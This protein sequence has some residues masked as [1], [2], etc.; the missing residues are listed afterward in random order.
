MNR[1]LRIAVYTKQ[2]SIVDIWW[3]N[4]TMTFML[5]TFVTQ[6]S[7]LL[8]YFSLPFHPYPSV[9]CIGTMCVSSG[10]THAHTH[11]TKHKKQSSIYETPLLF[12]GHA[13]ACVRACVC[14][15][16]ET[17]IVQ[18]QHISGYLAD[19]HPYKRRVELFY[20]IVTTAFSSSY[21]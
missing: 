13:W 14:V 4:W 7:G 17:F 18:V 5:T 12:N 19:T 10:F 15:C 3:G 1:H 6:Q 9:Q 8:I 11:T 16:V 21:S 20:S 2:F